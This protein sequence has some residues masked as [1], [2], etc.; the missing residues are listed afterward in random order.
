MIEEPRITELVVRLDLSKLDD[1]PIRLSQ[2]CGILVEYDNVGEGR[3][4][5]EDVP[6]ALEAPCPTCGGRPVL[7]EIKG[8]IHEDDLS[9]LHA[10]RGGT[11]PQG[12]Q[13]P[14]PFYGKL[15]RGE[16]ARALIFLEAK[17]AEEE[18]AE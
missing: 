10:F 7:V 18:P 15:E 3:N 2:I 16:R 14:I 6:F 13:L 8:F 4:W 12:Y 5:T 9:A 1:A 11:V 17:P